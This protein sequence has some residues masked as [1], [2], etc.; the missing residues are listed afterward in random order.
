MQC[1]VFLLILYLNAQVES[2]SVRAKFGEV[3]YMDSGTAQR[4]RTLL[5]NRAEYQITISVPLIILE[6]EN[7]PYVVV[8]HRERLQTL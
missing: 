8:P 1:V 5:V 7:H 4:I 3:P 2:L 6:K